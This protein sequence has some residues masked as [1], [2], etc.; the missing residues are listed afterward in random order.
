MSNPSLNGQTLAGSSSVVRYINLVKLPHTV[1]ALPFA[2]L[3]VVYASF[4][5]AVTLRVVLLVVVAFT[6][7]RFA[8]MGFNRIVDRRYDALNPRTRSRELP[9]GTLSAVE[10]WVAVVVAS[11]VFV[12]AASLL[13]PLCLVL[14]PAALTWILSYSFAKR[15]T[16]WSHGW[17]GAGLGIAPVGGYLAVTGAWGEPWWTLPV[18]A[19]AVLTW[20]AGFDMFYA[21]SDEEFDRALG[22]KSAVV[23]LGRAQSILTAKLLHRTTIAMLVLFAVGT[24]FGIWYYVGVACA[25]GILAYEHRLVMPADLSRLDAAFFRMNGVMS[26]VVALFALLDRAI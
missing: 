18:I 26:I 19:L 10:A 2:V 11:V 17:L 5:V 8:A 1:F 23:A 25:A 12:I 14:S 22:L 6:A 9:A 3:G 13:N 20:V 24:P 21:L 7:A 16:A 4:D 15:F